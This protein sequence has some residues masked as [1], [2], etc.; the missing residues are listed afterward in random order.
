MTFASDPSE[1]KVEPR[2]LSIGWAAALRDRSDQIRPG[3]LFFDNV[4]S[5]YQWLATDGPPKDSKLLTISA[6]DFLSITTDHN[7]SRG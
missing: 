7:V 2:Y 5:W 4:R 3:L 1:N 6:Q